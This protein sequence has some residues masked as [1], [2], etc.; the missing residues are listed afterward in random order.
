MK[1]NS[2]HPALWLSAPLSEQFASTGTIA[3]I[4]ALRR[5]IVTLIQ[6]RLTLIVGRRA[7][8]LT[9]SLSGGLNNYEQPPI[10]A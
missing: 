1:Y 4:M 7:S 5:P 9:C 10:M 2:K 3:T 8:A 6:A